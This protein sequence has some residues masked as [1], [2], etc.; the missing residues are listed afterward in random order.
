MDDL[1][2]GSS[3]DNAHYHR[4]DDALDKDDLDGLRQMGR[5]L[6]QFDVLD[7]LF[8]DIVGDMEWGDDDFD[9]TNLDAE[10]AAN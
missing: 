2:I 6:H 8:D 5:R 9:H 7:H 4:D 1:S 10:D 3:R